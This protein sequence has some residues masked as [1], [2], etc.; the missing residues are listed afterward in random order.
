MD[1]LP[2]PPATE[3]VNS[4]ISLFAVTLPLQSARIQESILEQLSTSLAAKS[5]QRDPGRKAA[6]TVNIAL[7]LL[8]TLKVTMSETLAIPGDLKS[9]PVEKY[10][11]EL[12]RVIPTYR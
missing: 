2:D 5:L 10:L 7:A 6:I 12:L 4:A 11:D 3:V 8:G 1:D 9:P